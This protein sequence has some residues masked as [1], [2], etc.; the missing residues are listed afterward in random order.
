MATEGWGV[1]AIMRLGGACGTTRNSVFYRLSSNRNLRHLNAHNV[2]R[3]H[4]LER[5]D[6]ITAVQRRRVKGCLAQCLDWTPRA[7]GLSVRSVRLKNQRPDKRVRKVS[8]IHE[9]ERIALEAH[10]YTHC[11]D[12]IRTAVFSGLRFGELIALTPMTSIMS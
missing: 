12:F 8:S 11:G 4:F 6:E 9:A 2:S 5:L 3:D 1:A 7:T 10:K